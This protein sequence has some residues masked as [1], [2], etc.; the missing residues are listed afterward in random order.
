MC[1][2]IKLKY[3]YTSWLYMYDVSFHKWHETI[4][5]GLIVILQVVKYR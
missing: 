4:I 3:S 2:V 5:S 1:E